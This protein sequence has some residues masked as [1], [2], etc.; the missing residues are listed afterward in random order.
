MFFQYFSNGGITGFEV[1]GFKSFVKRGITPAGI[2]LGPLEDKA[3]NFKGSSGPA[4]FSFMGIVP[5]VLNGLVLPAK[6]GI[7]RDEGGDFIESFS[8]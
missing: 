7:G 6:E 3:F 8:T 2:I 5:F 1:I 4:G